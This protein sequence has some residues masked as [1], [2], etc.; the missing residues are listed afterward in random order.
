MVACFRA[1][2]LV[3]L[4]STLFI[5]AGGV[6]KIVSKE[7]P[8][9]A[10]KDNQKV[11]T[12]VDKFEGNN[13]GKDKY[14]VPEGKG[15]RGRDSGRGGKRKSEKRKSG[16]RR[17]PWKL[18]RYL[19]ED[20]ERG[21]PWVSAKARLMIDRVDGENRISH[22]FEHTCGGNQER[23]FS[24]GHDGE[25]NFISFSNAQ[26]FP[27][28]AADCVMNWDRGQMRVRVWAERIKKN[29]FID[30]STYEKAYDWCY[31]GGT[32]YT[33]KKK[34]LYFKGARDV[35]PWPY[36]CAKSV[37]QTELAQSWG[38]PDDSW[39][40]EENR[41]AVA[42]KCAQWASLSKEV[43]LLPDPDKLLEKIKRNAI[44]VE[45]DRPKAKTLCTASWVDKCV[46]FNTTANTVCCCS[47]ECSDTPCP[48]APGV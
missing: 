20:D 38:A 16:K 35:K 23:N 21:L 42:A 25:S 3:L 30:M 1:G 32:V 12:L 27:E 8:K 26:H 11:A 18:T 7:K 44:Y 45:I 34:K 41:K 13:K 14:E 5:N 10:K 22:P 48:R 24:L 19:H 47:D 4:A 29:K 43:L 36:K 33:H 46:S 40:T 28:A 17:A 2:V 31:Y 37:Y 15:G 9:K 39:W 6:R